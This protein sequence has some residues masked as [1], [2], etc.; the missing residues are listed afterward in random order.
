MK[1]EKSTDHALHRSADQGQRQIDGAA[2]WPNDPFI[3]FR[4]TKD[5]MGLPP[6][7]EK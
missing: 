7:E 1:H 2:S 4:I 3:P 6:L 5:G